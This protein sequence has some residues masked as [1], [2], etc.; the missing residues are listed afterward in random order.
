M[1]PLTVPFKQ[2]DV[3]TSVPFKGNPVAV[4][5][6]LDINDDQITKEQ[7]QS[8]ATWTNLS[9]T[10]F[11]FKTKLKECDYKLRIFTP[12]KE[13]DFAGHPTIGSANAFLQFTKP[14]TKPKSLK[15]ECGVG[16]IDLKIDENDRIS[17]KANVNG[18]EVMDSQELKNEY[19]SALGDLKIINDPITVNTGI[20]WLVIFTQDSKTCFDCDPNYTKIAQLSKKYDNIGVI[21]AGKKSNDNQQ[22]EMRAFAPVI[23][24]NEDPVCGSGSISCITAIQHYEKFVHTTNISITQGGRVNRDGRLFTIIKVSEDKS[25]TY[26]TGGD[27]LCLVDGKINI[28]I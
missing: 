13:L 6:C 19:S 4:I 8:I 14:T 20:K 7:M 18:Y 10:T 17:L 5:N 24:V 3:F 1:A 12:V 15:Q 21:L 27:A 16:I 9:E 26:H 22:Y 28:T 23:N 25:I 11:L 2:M